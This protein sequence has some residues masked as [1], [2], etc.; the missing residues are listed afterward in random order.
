VNSIGKGSFGEIFQGIDTLHDN[1]EVAIKMVIS[2][3]SNYINC[4]NLSIAK[5]R[6]W[7]VRLRY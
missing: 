4:R 1:M 3:I 2:I 5:L 7:K 6:Y